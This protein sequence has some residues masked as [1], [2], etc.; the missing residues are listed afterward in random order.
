MIESP[1]RAA[2][3]LAAE[4]SVHQ[5]LNPF[6]AEFAP[7]GLDDAY[8]IQGELVA[9][10][11]ANGREVGGYKLAYTTATMQA[12]SG[13]REPALGYLFS[14]ELRASP[15]RL[16]AADYVHLGLECEMAVR[17]GQDLPAAGAPYTRETVAEAVSAVMASIEVIDIR[18]APD[19]DDA[20]KA[21]LGVSAN[22]WNAGVVLGAASETWR[23][24]D[25]TTARGT[26]HVNGEL[27]GE[28]LG[29]DVMG[30]PLEPLAW[31]A[32]ALAKRGEPLSAGMIVITGS[33]V[34]PKFLS[35]GDHAIVS[36]DG[37]GDAVLDVE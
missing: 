29:G 23:D 35:P 27:V 28:G 36:V 37:L 20:T 21:M 4:L 24:I 31:L 22:I 26:V 1:R 7:Q 16:K 32:N 10:R 19:I 5:A 9:M 13:L 14:D 6:P 2:E 8:A 3:H 18:A 15:A 33:L 11:R 25:L 17:L 34:A 12:R 30:H